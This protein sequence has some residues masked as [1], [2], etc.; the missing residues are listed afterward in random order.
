MRPFLMAAAVLA[1][2]SL[3]LA[4]SKQTGHDTKVEEQVK[5]LEEELRAAAVKGDAATFERLL[6][7]SYVTVN[8]HGLPRTKAEVIADFRSGAN[9]VESLALENVKVRVYGDTAVLTA[10]RTA[11]GALRGKDTSGRTRELRVF[12][13]L[14]GRW[15]AVAMQVTPIR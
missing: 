3:G 1:F 7:D 6:A 4:Q 5:Q 9:K 11:K 8:V 12:A 15:Q 2:G 14:N 10:D 13:K